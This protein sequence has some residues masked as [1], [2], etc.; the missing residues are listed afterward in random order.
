MAKLGVDRVKPWNS[1]RINFGL[2]FKGTDNRQ[3]LTID[4]KLKKVIEGHGKSL[5]INDCHVRSCNVM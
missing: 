4:F 5:N 3:I 1:V 2:D